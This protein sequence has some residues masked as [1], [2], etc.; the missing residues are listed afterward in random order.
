MATT[1]P[2]SPGHATTPGCH[3]DTP[4]PAREFAETRFR[5]PAIERYVPGMRVPMRLGEWMLGPDG[6]PGIG[7]FGVLVD[8]VIGMEIYIGRPAG[9]H[10]VT[11]ELSFDVLTSPPWHGSE[12][13]ARASSIGRDGDSGVARCEIVDGDGS[14]VAV[15]TG[16]LRLISAE[17]AVPADEEFLPRARPPADHRSLLATLGVVDGRID[18]DGDTA[19]M[20]V[21]AE[22]GFEN[23]GGSVHGGVLFCASELVT[24]G[25][26]EPGTPERTVSV[27]MHFV[28]PARVDLPVT[29]TAR[30]LHR[31]RSD[32][33]Y[34]VGT[35]GPAGKPYTLATVTR[36]RHRDPTLRIPRQ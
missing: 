26:A 2:D 3:T 1:T 9:T 12:L 20:E 13:V 36:R 4:D 35:H 31:G 22:P 33:V 8:T 30:I 29:A 5:L 18:R 14:L 11:T 21:A 16:R 19:R 32:S 10:S 28:R 23:G 6:T 24:A 15:A 17:G 27:R 25:L 34:Q 7:A